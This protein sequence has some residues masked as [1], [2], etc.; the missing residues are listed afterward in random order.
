MTASKKS[1]PRGKIAFTNGGLGRM[2][3]AIRP[4]ERFIQAHPENRV[5][6]NSS[7]DFVWGNKILQPKSYH[8]EMKNIF[9]DVIKDREWIE[10]EPYTDWEYYNQKISIG[11]AFDKHW[12]GKYSNDPEDYR[13]NIYLTEEELAF[14]R[15]ILNAAE[16]E[17]LDAQLQDEPELDWQFEEVGEFGQEGWTISYTHKSVKKDQ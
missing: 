16:K 9:N 4:L 12:N 17:W 3:S 11:Q 13:P 1:S 5:M 7:L 8:S 2:L 6:T 14:G 10:A 15:A